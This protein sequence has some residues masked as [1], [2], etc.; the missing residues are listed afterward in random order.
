M[1]II[2]TCRLTNAD[3]A[4]VIGDKAKTYKKK[5]MLDLSDVTHFHEGFTEKTLFVYLNSGNSYI[6]EYAFNEFYDKMIESL[7]DDWNNGN[8]TWVTFSKN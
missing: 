5:L 7:D 1:I 6:I 2:V 4:D 3:E 8:G